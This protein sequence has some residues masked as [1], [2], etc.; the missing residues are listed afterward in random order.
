MIS[1]ILIAF[2]AIFYLFF[3]ILCFYVGFKK[4]KRANEK[5]R[6]CEIRS[7]FKIIRG[8]KYDSKN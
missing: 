4:V 7:E 6:I 1:N 5:K 3:A 2:L 8:E